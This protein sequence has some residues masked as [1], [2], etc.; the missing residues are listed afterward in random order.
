MSSGT[1][2]G[3]TVINAGLVSSR[4]AVE[5]HP[6][7]AL[8]LALGSNAAG[9]SDIVILTIQCSDAEKATGLLG[10]REVL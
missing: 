5:F 2:S 1:F 10:W 7:R 9:E 6:Q 3:G 4:S 8:D